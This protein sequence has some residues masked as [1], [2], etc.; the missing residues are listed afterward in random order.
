M[1]RE[2][3]YFPNAIIFPSLW[4]NRLDNSS[5][6]CLN[7]NNILS[8]KH[9]FKDK[10]TYDILYLY[11]TWHET[12]LYVWEPMY[13]SPKYHTVLLFLDCAWS[14][15]IQHL[16]TGSKLILPSGLLSA[17]YVNCFSSITN[18]LCWPMLDTATET[19]AEQHDGTES[20]L[21]YKLFHCDVIII[22]CCPNILRLKYKLENVNIYSARIHIMKLWQCV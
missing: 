5:S 20:M 16:G 9:Y 4:S 10:W 15:S 7:R 18:T 19:N 22:S 8:E 14:G 13:I 2:E 12:F 3:V 6:S 1:E 21:Q 11:K 17:I